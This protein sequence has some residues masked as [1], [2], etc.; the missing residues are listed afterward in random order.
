DPFQAVP[1]AK[2]ADRSLNH[3]SAPEEGPVAGGGGRGKVVV[4]A[5]E[6]SAGQE[7]RGAPTETTT[8]P[9]DVVVQPVVP[10]AGSLGAAVEASLAGFRFAISK[11]AEAVKIVGG[12]REVESRRVLWPV[13]DSLEKALSAAREKGP[14]ETVGFQK[15]LRDF[16]VVQE[17]LRAASQDDDGG[18]HC[19]AACAAAAQGSGSDESVADS[20]PRVGEGGG[21]RAEGTKRPGAPPGESSKS[22]PCPDNGSASITS[23]HEGGVSRP[24]GPVVSRSGREVSEVRDREPRSVQPVPA[25]T[26]VASQP[27]SQLSSSGTVTL[28]QQEDAGSKSPPPPPTP[29][30]SAAGRQESP[31]CLV[32]DDGK[33]AE[34]SSVLPLPL[35]LPPPPAAAAAGVAEVS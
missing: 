8:G 9:D 26:T 7:Q 29:S 18:G 13:V 23:Q 24:A 1:G 6:S 35:P 20:G 28:L 33:F 27:T 22:L 10:P 14:V 32:G 5:V 11:L 25:G 34:T 12:K 4:V 19:L 16:S 21:G 15:L 31:A 30:E 3:S 2:N 17:E